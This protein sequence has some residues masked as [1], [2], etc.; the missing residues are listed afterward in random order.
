MA[1]SSSTGG[2]KIAMTPSAASR[3]QATAAKTGGGKV[4]SG[5]FAARAQSAATKNGGVAKK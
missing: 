4:T 1:K 3:I 2:G 5:S